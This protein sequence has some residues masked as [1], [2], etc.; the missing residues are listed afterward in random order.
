M[1][2]RAIST[3]VDVALCL[4]LIGAS[5][6]TLA[7]ATP[8]PAADTPDPT[9][10]AVVL[11]TATGGAPDGP[12]GTIADRLAGAAIATTR[13]TEPGVTATRH[14]VNATLATIP[15]HTQ[16]VAVWR[17][18]RGAPTT[19]RVTVGDTPPPMATVTTARL[20]VPVPP[21][22]STTRLAA[23]ARTGGYPA[24]ASALARATLSRRL[25]PCEALA[26]V[27]TACTPTA[28]LPQTRLDALTTRYATA[29][30]TRFDSP[31]AAA[32]AVTVDRVTLIVRRW[33]R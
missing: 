15:G 23:L 26:A 17:P 22:L 21:T 13:P 18:Y 32:A 8:P 10:V 7:T 9:P 27:R 19:G 33:S 31:T 1:T 28:A 20:T 29:L 5:V 4:L 12:G 16:V 2:D 24:V 6:A 25:R 11:A 14:R 30:R 3:V